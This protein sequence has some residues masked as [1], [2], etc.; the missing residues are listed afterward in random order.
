MYVSRV[1]HLILANQLGASS[2]RKMDSPSLSSKLPVPLH[3]GVVLHTHTHTHTHSVH[4]EMST[5]VI[6]QVL[7]RHPYC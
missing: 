6:I 3:L 2:L 1:N 5:G 4:A 7:F